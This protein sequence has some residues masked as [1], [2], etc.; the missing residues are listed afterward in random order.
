MIQK[1]TPKTCRYLKC[2]DCRV[3]SRYNLVQIHTFVH[4]FS[5]LASS[6]LVVRSW[7]DISRSMLPHLHLT[8]VV[9]R[10]TGH[11][12][13]WQTIWHKCGSPEIKWSTAICKC[14]LAAGTRHDT[15]NKT[16]LNL[17]KTTPLSDWM[18]MCIMG[19]QQSGL[20]ILYST[21]I[22]DPVWISDTSLSFMPQQCR[23]W[24]SIQ[25]TPS[26]PF[27][28]PVHRSTFWKGF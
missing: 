21:N 14:Y 23:S 8:I 17:K 15:Y 24:A 7:Q 12:P 19:S 13:V 18:H 11:G 4:F 5:H 22:M 25:R 20:W 2:T 16:L 6:A 26:Q 3:V 27:P 1:Q 28:N 10:H 9:R